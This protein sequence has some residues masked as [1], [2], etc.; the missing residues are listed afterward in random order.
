MKYAYQLKWCFLML[1]TLIV[2]YS[3]VR[4]SETNGLN[5]RNFLTLAVL[6][7][8]NVFPSWIVQAYFKQVDLPGS[9][10]NARSA[11]SII[12]GIIIA[13]LLNYCCALLV[14]SNSHMSDSSV[15]EPTFTDFLR[16]LITSLFLV[17]ICYNFFN[18]IY[19]NN[20]LQKT[21]LENEHF[22]QLQLRAQLLSLQQQISPHFLFNSF[23]ILKTIATD[24][25]TKK[26]VVQLS[27]V[28]RYLLNVN[29]RDVTSL[30]EELS[31][32]RSY[33]YILHQRFESALDVTIHVPEAYYNYV[34]PPLSLQLLMENAIKH[35]SVSIE[36][37]LQMEIS[38]QDNAKLVVKNSLLPR[39]T[40]EESTKLGLQNISERY[41]LLFRKDIEIIK[42]ADTFTVNLPLISHESYY[43]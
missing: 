40:P 36:H 18:F 35:N 23:S 42:T 39:K 9:L 4:L 31:F 11:I 6:I 43:H 12:A 8:L 20:I 38:I 14:P 32:V 17:M 28:Y 1:G 25:D 5:I 13:L 41:Q 7:V 33:L 26:F 37:P 24:P 19:T 10:R 21:Q 2:G 15:F 29:E 34:I 16:R 30:E 22:R 3:Y 27:H